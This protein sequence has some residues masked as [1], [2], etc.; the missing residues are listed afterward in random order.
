MSMYL[1]VLLTFL[2]ADTDAK[3]QQLVRRTL[4]LGAESVSGFFC[5][6]GLRVKHTQPEK[7]SALTCG[8][9]FTHD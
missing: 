8:P 9:F 7:V 1:H 4:K 3:D 2:A 6:L 5:S